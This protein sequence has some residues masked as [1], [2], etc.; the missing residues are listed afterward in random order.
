VVFTGRVDSGALV[1]VAAS[2]AAAMVSP[3]S[4]ILLQLEQNQ[5]NISVC[6]ANASET[7]GTLQWLLAG[8]CIPVSTSSA[9]PPLSHDCY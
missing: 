4:D 5:L 8:L 7:D 3:A 1:S 6:F 9:F 2:V